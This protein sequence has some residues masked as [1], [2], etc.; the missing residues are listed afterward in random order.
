MKKLYLVVKVNINTGPTSTKMESW[1]EFVQC[2]SLRLAN[3]EN[4]ISHIYEGDA[5]VCVVQSVA[6]KHVCAGDL[7]DFK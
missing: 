2:A 6:F 1:L 5:W 4:Y 7:L 3:L